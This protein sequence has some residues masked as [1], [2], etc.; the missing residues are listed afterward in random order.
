M[1]VEKKQC[2]KLGY[3]PIGVTPNP[4]QAGRRKSAPPLSST[5]AGQQ[6]ILLGAA[7]GSLCLPELAA[8][9]EAMN[10]KHLLSQCP[11]RHS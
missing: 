4:A 7:T 10:K 9:S 8:G 11:S 2:M 3:H 5:L 6:P 1:S